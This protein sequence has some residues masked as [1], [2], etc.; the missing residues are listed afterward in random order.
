MIL[1]ACDYSRGLTY[2]TVRWSIWTFANSIDW[3]AAKSDTQIY[4]ALN[5]TVKK[6]NIGT[7]STDYTDD[8]GVQINAEVVTAEL[9]FADDLEQNNYIQVRLQGVFTAI[10]SGNF[11]FVNDAGAASSLTNIPAALMNSGDITQVK[12]MKKAFLPRLMFVV[13]SAGDF[14]L[15]RISVYGEVVSFDLINP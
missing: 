7:E 10:G 3:L 9:P 11:K 5:D 2:D 12:V 13:N 4:L 14:A 6:M 8:Q 1:L 15:K